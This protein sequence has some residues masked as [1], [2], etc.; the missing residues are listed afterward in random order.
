MH[1]LS[2]AVK[3]GD[4]IRCRCQMADDIIQRNGTAEGGPE[5]R[6]GETSDD[7]FTSVCF[8]VDGGKNLLMAYIDIQNSAYLANP[9]IYFVLFFFLGRYIFAISRRVIHRGYIGRYKE[10]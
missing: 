1:E 4:E 2:L 9:F 10:H 8:H 6:L 7:M 3:S 5:P